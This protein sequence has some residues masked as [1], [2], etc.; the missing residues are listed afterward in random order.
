MNLNRLKGGRGARRAV[1]GLTVCLMLGSGYV[2]ASFTAT[3]H[4]AAQELPQA[5]PVAPEAIA[6]ESPPPTE[7]APTIPAPELSTPISS[8]ATPALTLVVAAN[9]VVGEPVLATASLRNG[10]R[11]TG[12]LIFT[13]Y[14]GEDCAGALYVERRLDV[15]AGSGLT[16][17]EAVTFSDVGTFA[18]QATYSGDR[19]NEGVVSACVLRRVDASAPLTLTVTQGSE[20]AF[21]ILTDPGTETDPDSLTYVMA[22]AVTVHVNGGTEPWVVECSV[23]GGGNGVDLAW[24]LAGT[25]SWTAFSDG[26]CAAAV[27]GGDRTLTFH[28]RVRVDPAADPGHFAFDVTYEVRPLVLW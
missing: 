15:G 7:P 10:D 14:Y 4:A 9:A 22:D 24:Q 28:Y 11:P 19:T 25:T 3:V 5:T 1:I 16:A 13:I 26:P 21:G 6:T 12:R 23:V 18:W 20:V 2:G 27:D 17:T 8:K